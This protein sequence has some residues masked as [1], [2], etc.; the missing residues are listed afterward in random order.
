VAN[1]DAL[2]WIGELQEINHT[3]FSQVKIK[4]RCP[5]ES[6]GIF[7][8]TSLAILS[9]TMRRG[10]DFCLLLFDILMTQ[11]CM[12][13]N[14]F[15]HLTTWQSKGDFWSAWNIKQLAKT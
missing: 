8:W 3:R 6:D 9:A 1:N 11:E 10:F 14:I 13:E 12:I 7:N 5:R 4:A 2:L 15:P